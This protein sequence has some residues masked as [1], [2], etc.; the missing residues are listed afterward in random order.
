MFIEGYNIKAS[1]VASR[2]DHDAMLRFAAHHGINPV[3]EKFEMSELGIKQA[4]E[5]LESGQV[6][7]RG[8]LVAA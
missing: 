3:I 6:R 4:L 8:V 2:A 5:R 7:Y 1:L